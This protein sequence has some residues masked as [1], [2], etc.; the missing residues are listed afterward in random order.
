MSGWLDPDVKTHDD[1]KSQTVGVLE[2]M[3]K[4]LAS[5]QL[6]LGDMACAPS[7]PVR[8]GRLQPSPPN[9]KSA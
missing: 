9:V 2:D 6:A 1:I 3:Q 8:R 5:R 7:A 4:F